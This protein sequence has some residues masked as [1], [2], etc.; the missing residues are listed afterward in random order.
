[1]KSREKI[2][3]LLMGDS[4]IF[5]F[6][7]H[8]RGIAVECMLKAWQGYAYLASCYGQLVEQWTK[9]PKFEGLDQAGCKWQKGQVEFF[10]R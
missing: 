10:L 6:L 4:F 5:L 8:L 7:C 9:D 3:I 1:M 2:R